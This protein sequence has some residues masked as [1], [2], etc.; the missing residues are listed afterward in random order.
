M[1]INLFALCITVGGLAVLFYAYAGYPALLWLLNALKASRREPREGLPPWPHV[2]I[3]ISAYNEEQSIKA[4]LE[5]LLALD[6]PREQL[7]IV[8][9][10]DGSTD[11]T[12]EIVA[13]FAAE[14]VRLFDF[15]QRRGKANVLN[16]LVPAAR[17]QI[18]VLTDANTFFYAD[19]VKRLVA[20]LIRRPNACAVVGRLHLNSP[21]AKGNLD[22]I[23]WRYETWLKSLES[24]F[25]AVL[26]ANGAIYAFRRGD[27]R[28]LP[29]QTIV[30][31]FLIPLLIRLETGGEVIFVPEA[32]AWE[33]SPERVR[34][35]FRRRV[36]IGAGDF[37]ALQWTWRLLQPWRG[38]VA[39]AYLSHKV[40]R[41]L[42]P[43]FMLAVFVGNLLLL[44]EPLFNVL[45]LVQSCF[46]ALALSGGL[47]QP[48]PGIGRIATAAY[49]F[50]VLN[51]ALFF[52]MLWLAVGGA[53]PTWTKSARGPIEASRAEGGA[54][55]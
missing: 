47:L 15:A 50:V 49:Y 17:S 55:W 12:A 33:Q 16:D 48:T 18:V 3:V 51:A 36:R 37:Q 43:W 41:W 10:S 25:G 42:G 20:A 52:G 21:T 14:G 28:P 8:V 23:Y 39:L 53:G 32:R 45:F 30:D 24:R 38:M 40:L 6:Y 44:G 11:R 5:N 35:E 29:P 1:H 4:R 13:S 26:G 46:Y 31:D 54:G 2:S 22:G 34:D 9:G 27:F 19:A 7:E